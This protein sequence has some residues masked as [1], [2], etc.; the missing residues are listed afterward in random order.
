MA[1]SLPGIADQPLHR[2]KGGG[3]TQTGLHPLL[4]RWLPG[5][6]RIGF[7]FAL[8]ARQKAGHL[9]DQG[10]L[11]HVEHVPAVPEPHRDVEVH[12]VRV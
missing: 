8:T 9:L 11:G 6:A 12:A 4:G 5:E 7:R 1:S 10:G 2:A 3:E